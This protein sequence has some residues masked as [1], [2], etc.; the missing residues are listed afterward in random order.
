VLDFSERNTG[1]WM[2]VNDGVMGGLSQSAIRAT[3]EGSAVFSGVVSLEN[4]GGFASVR[5]A[6]D[7]ADLAAF[8]GLMVRVR[9]DGKR[10]RL[11]LRTNNRFDGIAYQGEFETDGKGWQ[12][13][14]IPFSSFDPTFRGR[15]VTG[16][17]AMDTKNIQQISFMIADKQ[18]GRFELEIAWVRA[19]KT[20]ADT[21]SSD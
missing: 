4:N 10:Y 12:E 11:R 16:A 18:A 20:P 15:T 7:V 5:T 2:T 8:E 17:P 13:I 14:P 19:Y 21:G 3:G 9:G 1:S 6:L